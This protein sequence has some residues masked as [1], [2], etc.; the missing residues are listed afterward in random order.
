MN[1][2]DRNKI[3][4][5]FQEKTDQNSEMDF[6]SFTETPANAKLPMYTLL[7]NPGKQLCVLYPFS[8]QTGLPKMN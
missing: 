6:N 2:Q 4:S 3:N 7:T 5:C 1:F 8:I